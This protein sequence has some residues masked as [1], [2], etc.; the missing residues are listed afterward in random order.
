MIR[1]SGD[2]ASRV[3]LRFGGGVAL[4]LVRPLQIN[5]GVL[6][7]TDDP[8]TAWRWS[9][10]WYVGVAVDPVLLVEAIGGSPRKE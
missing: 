2:E 3:V 10:S 1:L 5:A 9:R 7:G 8:G 6:L 4:N